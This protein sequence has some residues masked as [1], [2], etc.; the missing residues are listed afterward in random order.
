MIIIHASVRRVW[1][2]AAVPLCRHQQLEWSSQ[3]QQP[4]R[5]QRSV[6]GRFR[7]AGILA[8]CACFQRERRLKSGITPEPATIHAVS[9]C[10]EQEPVARGWKL[11]SRQA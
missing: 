1:V 8:P 4:T 3:A 6:P 7:A 2:C 11:S 5:P 10:G 9:A